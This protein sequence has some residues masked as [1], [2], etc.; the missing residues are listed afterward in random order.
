[1]YK[2][3]SSHDIRWNFEKFLINRHGKPVMRFSTSMDPTDMREYI[4]NLL[5]E[6]H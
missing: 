6:N 5:E 3:M 1:M 4:T 2:P